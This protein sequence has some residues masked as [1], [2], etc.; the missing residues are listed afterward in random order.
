MVKCYFKYINK[1]AFISKIITIIKSFNK[2]LLAPQRRAKR[3]G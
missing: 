3:E 2:S 1:I